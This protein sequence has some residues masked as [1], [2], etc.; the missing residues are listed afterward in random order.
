MAKTVVPGSDD[1]QCACRRRWRILYER[2]GEKALQSYSRNN[3]GG[4]FEK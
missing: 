2:L 4:G 1:M 3:R